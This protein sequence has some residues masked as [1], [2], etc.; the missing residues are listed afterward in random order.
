MPFAEDFLAPI[1]FLA[2]VGVVYYLFHVLFPKKKKKQEP[3][4]PFDERD[5]FYH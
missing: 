4:Y 5:I 2:I 3:E 1:L